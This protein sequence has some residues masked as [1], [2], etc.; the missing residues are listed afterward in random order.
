MSKKLKVLI[1]TVVV[2]LLL[3]VSATATVM[4]QGDEEEQTAPTSEEAGGKGLLERVA[5]ILGID[6]EDLAAAFKQARQE[7]R[8]D[9]FIDRVNQAVTGG[10]IT[11]EQGE[12]IITWWEQKPEVLSPGMFQHTL[13]FRAMP[14]FHMRNG[15]GGRFCPESSEQAD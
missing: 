8:E 12:E 14:R 1:S 7:M 11:P 10:L 5:E 4:A 15:V 9:V 13:R 6:E 2:A 3:T